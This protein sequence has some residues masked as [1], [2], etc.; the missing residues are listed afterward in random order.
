MTPRASRTRISLVGA[1]A[2][3]L[4]LAACSSSSG[5]GNQPANTSAACKA[6]SAYQGHSGTQVSIFASIISPESDKYIASWK[7]FEDCTGIKI[8]YEGSNDF[9][10][11]LPVRVQGGN[12]PDIAFIP[13]PGLLSRM[14]KTGNVIKAPD[15][16]ASN[17]DQNW[18]KQWKIYGTVD[19]T[20]YAAPMSSNLKSIV[21]YSPKAF[22]AAGYTVPTTW[23]D[24]M[25]LSDKI[26]KAGK[27]PWCGGIGSGTATGWPAT[28]WLEEIVMRQSGPDVYD[29]W[30]THD[31]KFDSPE[32]K[33][34]MD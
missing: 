7:Q 21:W 17:V 1:A 18:N 22:K 23:N 32:I 27:K 6:Y 14:V 12:A 31:V 29:K 24:L 34:A 9:E 19:G 16:V 3:A 25:S 30:I 4:L 15:Q 2:A 28:D 26:A 33:K 13:Q 8:N 5:G 11:Q 20:F 10:S